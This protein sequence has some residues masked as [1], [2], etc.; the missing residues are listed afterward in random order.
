M[1][2]VLKG[3]AL[4]V[5]NDDK[6]GVIGSIGTLLGKRGINVGRLQVGLD[7]KTKT[8]LA[9]WNLDV[10]VSSP[11]VEELRQIEHVRTVDYVVI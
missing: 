7:E 9:L 11:I 1:D 6:P 5:R 2:A 4:I 3:H 8:A 10:E